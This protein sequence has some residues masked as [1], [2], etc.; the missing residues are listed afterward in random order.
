MC[1][2]WWIIYEYLFWR[3]DLNVLRKILYT[4]NL[5]EDFSTL[6]D[7]FLRSHRLTKSHHQVWESLFWIVGH[8]CQRNF[9]NII[10]H[11]IA[12][13][14]PQRQKVSFFCWTCQTYQAQNQRSQAACNPKIPSLKT[15]LHGVWKCHTFPKEESK[16]QSCLHS[17]MTLIN[18]NTDQSC[19]LVLRVE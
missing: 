14:Y 3:Q 12:F 5:E 2:N 19:M 11:Y 8:C 6:T 9:Q 1:A 4:H 18:C 10:S 16:Q 17:A 15:S 13:V 7:S